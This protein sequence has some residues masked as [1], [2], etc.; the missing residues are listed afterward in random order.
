M[1]L[2]GGFAQF[3]GE[4]GSEEWD[5]ERILEDEGWGVVDLV[6]GA[7]ESH[8]ESGAGWRGLLHMGLVSALG[9]C[10]LGLLLSQVTL[11]V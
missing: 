1:Q 8:A 7:A 11:P 3:F 10:G 6:R 4:G 9:R 2:C 5:G